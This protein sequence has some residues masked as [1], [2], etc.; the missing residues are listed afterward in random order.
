MALQT[1]G[2]ISLA[3]IAIERG[4]VSSNISLNTASNNVNQSSP[5][6]PDSIQPHAVSE[7]YGYDQSAGAA[8]YK[9]FTGTEAFGE[10]GANFEEICSVPMGTTY[11]FQGSGS[12]P[13]IGDPVKNGNGGFI[14]NVLIG[15]GSKSGILHISS[16]GKVEQI[17]P[18]GFLEEPIGK[19]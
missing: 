11:K 10:K 1:S 14:A 17:S 6:R 15:I 18:C 3:S 7:F 2:Q 16:I 8:V 12:S 4:L 9:D 5:A 19:K 13:A